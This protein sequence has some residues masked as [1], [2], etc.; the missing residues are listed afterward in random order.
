MPFLGS[1]MQQIPPLPVRIE[2][3]RTE[4]DDGQKAT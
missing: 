1:K 2:P 3:A 4:K